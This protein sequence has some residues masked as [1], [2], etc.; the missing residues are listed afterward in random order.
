MED[1]D[2]TLELADEIIRL[3]DS[4]SQRAVESKQSAIKRAKEIMKTSQ[5]PYTQ[6]LLREVITYAK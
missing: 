6:D 3:Q 2:R 5:N 4:F 1:L